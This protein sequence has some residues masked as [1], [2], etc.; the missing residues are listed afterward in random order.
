[1]GG[2]RVK[3]AG[4]A[5]VSMATAV[6]SVESQSTRAAW[7][8]SSPALRAPGVAHATLSEWLYRNMFRWASYVHRFMSANL[9][10]SA[11]HQSAQPTP[12]PVPVFTGADAVL[13]LVIP[14]AWAFDHFGEPAGRM[15]D[16]DAGLD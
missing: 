9:S 7:P 13:I 5:V 4:Q 1:L 11:G 14:P 10:W 2:E 3:R 12:S 8:T 16:H 6:P 15:L